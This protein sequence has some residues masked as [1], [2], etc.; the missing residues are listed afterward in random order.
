VFFPAPV[1]IPSSREEDDMKFTFIIN[2][3]D[4]NST[5]WS[6]D[7]LAEVLHKEADL[8]HGDSGDHRVIRDKQGNVIGQ[9]TWWTYA[10]EESGK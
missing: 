5:E 3:D 8:I 4:A 7:K 1:N 10:K 6:R 9:W 2:C